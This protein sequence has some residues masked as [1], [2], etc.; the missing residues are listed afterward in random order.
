MSTIAGWGLT[1]P[2]DVPVE[3]AEAF[4]D[5]FRTSLESKNTFPALCSQ[6]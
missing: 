4:A 3:H 1:P 5:F 2:V 6:Y